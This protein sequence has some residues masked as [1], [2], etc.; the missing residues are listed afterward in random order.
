MQEIIQ[1][2]D[3]YLNR[4]YAKLDTLSLDKYSYDMLIRSI[5]SI[6]ADSSPS[7][8]LHLNDIDCSFKES[9]INIQ[10]ANSLNC[11]GG[12]LNI[13]VELTNGVITNIE[14]SILQ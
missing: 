10:T 3:L 7:I 4:Y 8:G 5:L 6:I 1:K 9:Y 2:I 13:Y 14:P 11:Y 12:R